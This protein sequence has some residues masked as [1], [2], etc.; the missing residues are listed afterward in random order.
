MNVRQ[1]Y[2]YQPESKGVPQ[3]FCLS[4][5]WSDMSI[6]QSLRSRGALAELSNPIINIL[7]LL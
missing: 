4:L 5:Q 3:A 7:K 6:E 1:S 2:E